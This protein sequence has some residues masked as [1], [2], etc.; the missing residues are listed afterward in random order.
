M[1]CIIYY[2][3]IIFGIIPVEI[4]TM[5]WGDMLIGTVL[6]M[7]GIEFIRNS[8]IYNTVII[9]LMW[10]LGICFILSGAFVLLLTILG[11]LFHLL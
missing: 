1:A 3:I 10:L 4:A 7:G 8:Y 6:I 9:I 5:I 11:V 2:F